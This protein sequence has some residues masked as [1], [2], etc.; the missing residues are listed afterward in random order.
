MIK[1]Q[2]VELI[3]R[4]ASAES[5]ERFTVTG[6][7]VYNPSYAHKIVEFDGYCCDAGT[8][9]LHLSAVATVISNDPPE[10]RK[11][12]NVAIGERVEVD[13]TVYAIVAQRYGDPVLLPAS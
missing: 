6:P 2:M 1:V 7:Q 12:L 11:V 10:R 3:D 9:H 5:A 8:G 13:G 4:I